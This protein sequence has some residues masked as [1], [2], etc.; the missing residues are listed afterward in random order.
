[1]QPHGTSYADLVRDPRLGTTFLALP[2]HG[3]DIWI[4]LL[5]PD[6]ID[7]R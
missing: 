3:Y 5:L 4:Y 2:Y 6:E 7:G 1:M